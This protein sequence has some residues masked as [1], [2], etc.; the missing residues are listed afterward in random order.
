MVILSSG[1]IAAEIG[2]DRDRVSYAIR[3]TGVKPIGRA[4]IV[5]LF[6]ESAVNT[7]R[8][9]LQSRQSKEI[10]MY[11]RATGRAKA[12]R[13]TAAVQSQNRRTVA[14][15]N[16][17]LPSEAHLKEVIGSLLLRL[18]SRRRCVSLLAELDRALRMYVDSKR[19]RD[20]DEG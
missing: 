19:R 2:A 5:R 11:A 15:E 20:D 16:P 4:G 9:F 7:I 6:P 3:K 13:G 1:Q 10:S 18:Q 17:S 12:C 8:E 14:Y